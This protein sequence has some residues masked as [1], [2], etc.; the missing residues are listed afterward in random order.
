MTRHAV[1]RYWDS[2]GQ[3]L[4][5]GV[6]KHPGRRRSQ[7]KLRSPW[8]AAATEESVIWFPDAQSAS[9][10]EQDA[11]REERPLHNRMQPPWAVPVEPSVHPDGDSTANVQTAMGRLAECQQVVDTRLA[12]FHAAIAAAIESGERQTD[13]VRQTGYTRET[14]RRICAAAKR[15]R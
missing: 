1:Y 12:E 3:L 14:I 2:A 15:S 8:F 4:Y 10:A 9:L 11:I 13:L 7:H 6:T 5:V